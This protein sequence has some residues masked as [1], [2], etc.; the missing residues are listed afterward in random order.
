M[1]KGWNLVFSKPIIQRQRFA[2][3]LSSNFWN[4]W[5]NVQESRVCFDDDDRSI[6][7]FISNILLANCLKATVKAVSKDFSEILSGVYF[8]KHLQYK[9]EKPKIVLEV[10]WWIFKTKMCILKIEVEKIKNWKKCFYKFLKV[11]CLNFFFTVVMYLF[12][13]HY[14]Y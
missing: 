4:F 13:H 6:R 7:S 1:I 14:F 9:L 5:E 2:G 10:W 3:V 12:F 11:T 8:E